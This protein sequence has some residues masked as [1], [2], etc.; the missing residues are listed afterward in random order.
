MLAGVAD[1]G[2]HVVLVARHDDAERLDLEE[3][4]SVL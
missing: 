4:A 2:L 1:Q 3:L